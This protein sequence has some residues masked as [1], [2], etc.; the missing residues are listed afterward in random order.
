LTITLD[1]NADKTLVLYGPENAIEVIRQF[2]SR[3]KDTSK[4]IVDSS[5]PQAIVNVKEYADILT[6]DTV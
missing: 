4:L 2:Y 1:A 5:G 3:V 6:L